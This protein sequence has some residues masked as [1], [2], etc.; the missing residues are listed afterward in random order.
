MSSSIWRRR[1]S[2]RQDPAT[3]RPKK[4]AFGPWI[5]PALRV[6]ASLKVLRGGF[7][8]VFGRT[9][10]R[11]AERALLASYERMVDEIAVG[12]TPANHAA[13][14]ALASLPQKIRG[15]GPVK[16]KSMQAAKAEEASLLHAFREPET[17]RATLA[18]E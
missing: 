12:L 8:D 13:A 15:F 4:I 2:P 18:A 11:R 10:E 17:A 5:F 3:G 14:V 1:C 9:H 16:E 7:F 6:L